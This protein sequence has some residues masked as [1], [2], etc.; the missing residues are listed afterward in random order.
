M[1]DVPDD[2]LNDVQRRVKSHTLSGQP[3][4]DSQGAA[5]ELAQHALPAYFLDFET[6]QF[7]VPIWKGTRPYSQI[8]FQFSLHRL[9]ESGELQ[10]RDFLD[11]SGE[12][13]SLAFAEALIA[14]C[15]QSGPVYVYNAG[16]ETARVKELAV[17]FP[18]LKTALHAINARV[19]DLLPIARRHFYHPSQQ[20]SWSIKAVLP[21]I[22]DDLRYDTL[23]GVQDGTMAM[24]AYLEAIKASCTGER[25]I[26]IRGQLLNYCRLDT[27]ALVRVWQHFS[28]YTT[29]AARGA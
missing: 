17:R 7:A 21:A 18:N 8:P 10:H 22:A 25:N 12:D 26:Q 5:A 23:S 13:P 2:Y 28:G 20:G 6:I 9:S 1:R 14:A 27:L 11:L 4:F 29:T 16:F 19:V 24:S 3:Y 15:D